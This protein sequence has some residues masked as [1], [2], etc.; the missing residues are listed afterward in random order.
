M[1][2]KFKKASAFKIGDTVSITLDRGNQEQLILRHGQFVRWLKGMQCPNIN[3]VNQ[4]DPKC[5]LCRNGYIYYAP[6]RIKVYNETVLHRGYM[7]QTTR[8]KVIEVDRVE[9]VTETGNKIFSFTSLIEDDIFRFNGPE[10]TD[11][12]PL[13]VDY[14]YDPREV[15]SS[16]EKFFD[17][18]NIVVSDLVTEV[19]AG[20][21]VEHNIV[22]IT[23]VR[24]VSKQVDIAFDTFARNIVFPTAGQNISTDDFILVE[25]TVLEPFTFGL[26]GQNQKQD[27]HK[28]FIQAE[29]DATL[30]TPYE[31]MLGEPDIVTPLLG[32]QTINQVITRGTTD[33]DL[34]NVFEAT[35]ILRVAGKTGTV[36]KIN[37]DYKLF[38]Q[39]Q[40][41]WLVGGAAPTAGDSYSIVLKYRPSYT[42][43]TDKSMIRTSENERFPRKV[44]L[45]LYDRKGKFDRFNEG[46][47]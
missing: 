15:F 44:G 24:N 12:E 17:G 45:K 32:E 14:W 28:E 5:T 34:F 35:E 3:S 13:S 20:G 19:P 26:L 27:R 23:K 36:F 8:K 31:F 2:R 6:D 42:I 29:G 30:I 16:C 40:I 9:V 43:F 1:A 21:D 18:V 41:Q 10:L 7:A 4:H 11:S 22:S 39:N 46:P 38:G 25:G 47:L 33:K 37:V